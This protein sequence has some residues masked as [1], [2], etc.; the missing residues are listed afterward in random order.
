[1][2]SPGVLAGGVILATAG[3]RLRDIMGLRAAG[4]ADD[5]EADGWDGCG[6]LQCERRFMTRIWK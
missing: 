5:V 1:M 6:M 2:T 4:A 3:A